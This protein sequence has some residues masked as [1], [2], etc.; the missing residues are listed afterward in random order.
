[1]SLSIQNICPEILMLKNCG[2]SF[3]SRIYP[4][5]AI[6]LFTDNESLPQYK[7]NDFYCA[8]CFDIILLIANYFMYINDD[9]TSSFICAKP[10]VYPRAQVYSDYPQD[11]CLQGYPQI[12]PNQVS[13]QQFR[14]GSPPNGQNP[15]QYSSQSH[16]A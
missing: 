11:Y 1:M 5:Y 6:I 2:L 13:P 12:Y 4:S 8:L 10:W 14:Q 15:P 3:N 16:S 7:P 9:Q